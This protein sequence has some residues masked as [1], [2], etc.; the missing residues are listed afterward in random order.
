MSFLADNM[1]SFSDNCL[2]LLF[3]LKASEFW[4]NPAEDWLDKGTPWTVLSWPPG[5]IG[6]KYQ[7]RVTFKFKF[8]SSACL[9]EHSVYLLL[10]SHSN[11][12]YHRVELEP[13]CTWFLPGQW[14]WKNSHSASQHEQASLMQTTTHR[15]TLQLKLGW[16]LHPAVLLNP[17]AVHPA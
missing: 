1:L 16:A 14:N 3:Y 11:P 13:L 15:N 5:I 10:H 17:D 8:Q 2:I 6:F 7:R 9:L 12:N 4:P